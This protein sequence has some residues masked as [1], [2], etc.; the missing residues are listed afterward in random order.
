MGDNS[1]RGG[2]KAEYFLYMMAVCTKSCNIAASIFFLFDWNVVNS[3]VDS[4]KMFNFAPNINGTDMSKQEKEDKAKEFWE[5]Y[6]ATQG[7]ITITDPIV[8][9]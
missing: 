5:Y 7:S 8:L 2:Q 3:F 9:D 4:D 1:K 6:E